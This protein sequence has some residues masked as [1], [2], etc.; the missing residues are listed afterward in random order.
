MILGVFFRRGGKEIVRIEGK[1]DQYVGTIQFLKNAG[2]LL[3]V[4]TLLRPEECITISERM[5]FGR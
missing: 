1:M 2:C 3:L 4:A 5:T